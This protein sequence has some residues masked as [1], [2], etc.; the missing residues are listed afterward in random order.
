MIFL[1]LMACLDWR[2]RPFKKAEKGVNLTRQ[3]GKVTARG[4]AENNEEQ[5]GGLS[6]VEP[7]RGHSAT[8]TRA[9]EGCKEQRS[10]EPGRVS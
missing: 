10:T 2:A 7:D 3:D 9:R 5:R 4:R 1:G 6:E 8:N